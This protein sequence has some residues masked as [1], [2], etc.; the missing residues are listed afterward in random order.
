M[1][2]PEGAELGHPLLLGD[3]SKVAGV[4]LGSKVF[5][6]G[7]AYVEEADEARE[8]LRYLLACSKHPEPFD[9][10]AHAPRIQRLLRIEETHPPRSSK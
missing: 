6:V 9:L 7:R 8:F 3:P 1:L 10:K 2:G 5:V 4:E